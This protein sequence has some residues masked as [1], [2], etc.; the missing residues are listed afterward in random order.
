SGSEPAGCPA[1]T[2]CYAVTTHTR[3]IST[4]AT[5]AEPIPAPYRSRAISGGIA[6]VSPSPTSATADQRMNVPG[7]YSP[8]KYGTRANSSHAPAIAAASGHDHGVVTSL[9]SRLMM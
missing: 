1:L 2:G 7:A 3:P 6:K 5:I 9:R 8:N 4:A